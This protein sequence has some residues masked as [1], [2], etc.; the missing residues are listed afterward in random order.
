MDAATNLDVPEAVIAAIE[1]G[2]SPLTFEW[3]APRD[4]VVLE[5]NAVE[6]M[7]AQ[8][9]DVLFRVGSRDGCRPRP[10]QLI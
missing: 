5:R 2:S 6:G 3:S 7:R 10:S 1:K 8:L 4:G 9:G